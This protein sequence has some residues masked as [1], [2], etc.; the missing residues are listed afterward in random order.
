MT[1]K[2]WSRL[3]E[4]EDILE[5]CYATLNKIPL[6]DLRKEHMWLPSKEFLD[7]LAESRDRAFRYMKRNKHYGKD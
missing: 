4:V 1:R 3:E 2:K 6:A 7:E 5:Q